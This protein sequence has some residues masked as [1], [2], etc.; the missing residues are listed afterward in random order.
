VARTA[1]GEAVHGPPL[2]DVKYR[3]LDALPSQRSADR[4]PQALSGDLIGREPLD[5]EP[6]DAPRAGSG[7]DAEVPQLLP[8][9][10]HRTKCAQQIGFGEVGGPR[11]RAAAGVVDARREKRR[12]LSA[13]PDRGR[14]FRTPAAGRR[15]VNRRRYSVAQQHAAGC[16][17]RSVLG[18][19]RRG[20]HDLTMR[21]VAEIESIGAMATGVRERE[22]AHRNRQRL[23]RRRLTVAR[24]LP[25][26]YTR[27]VGL[28][29]YRYDSVAA[30][31]LIDPD[32]DGV[33][34]QRSR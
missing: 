22:G 15:V 11:R 4:D 7:E 5:G 31:G 32:T 10:T 29:R 21:L 6:R 12:I 14:D 1:A 17:R 20:A 30:G 26:D 13:R 9:E 19:R 27:H 33:S 2:A 18:C 28:E 25:S 3:A 16:R 34:R 8:D 24:R 23:E